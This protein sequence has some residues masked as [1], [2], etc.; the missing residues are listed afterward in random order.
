MGL[1]LAMSV[2][3]L[4]AA[5][6]MAGQFMS[7]QMGFAMA[8]AVDPET[9]ATS[10]VLTQF[11][12]LFTILIFFSL[13]G[14]HML[15]K[16]LAKSFYVVPI[17]SITFNPAIARELIWAGSEMFLLGIKIAAP[18]LVALF[19]S[20]LCLGII[21]RTVPQVEIL[22]IGFPINLGIGIIL[23]SFILLD[24]LPFLMDLQDKMGHSLIRLL[25]MM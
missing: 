6:Q 11:L 17:N 5:S 1:I 21:A 10:S 9:G 25:H 15:I 13:N 3:M 7:F 19:L 16:V 4:F 22:T 24:I 23:F 20:N 18:I 14:H 12:Y 8:R 2:R